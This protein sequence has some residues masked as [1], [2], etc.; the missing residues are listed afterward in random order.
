[1]DDNRE[2]DQCGVETVQVTERVVHEGVPY[3]LHTCSVCE[4]MTRQRAWPE[5]LTGVVLST[6]GQPDLCKSG[7]PGR[8]GR[9][10]RSRPSER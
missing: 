10:S 3:T 6:T 2:C 7:T 5:N 9:W 8:L 4:T 1:V